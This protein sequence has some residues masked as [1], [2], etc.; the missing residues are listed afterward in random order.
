MP[1]FAIENPIEVLGRILEETARVA[2]RRQFFPN[3]S[4]P[5]RAHETEKIGQIMRRGAEGGEFVP[6]PAQIKSRS[7]P[8][9]RPAPF[10]AS[11]HPRHKWNDKGVGAK[12]ETFVAI[13]AHKWV[14]PHTLEVPAGAVEFGED[15]E[16]GR[17]C[18]A[19]YRVDTET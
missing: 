15:N 9:R 12:E 2:Q 16:I 6:S 7:G 13:G 17:V 8:R 18:V 14:R 19:S 4:V 1:H 11:V 5:R 3:R 10:H